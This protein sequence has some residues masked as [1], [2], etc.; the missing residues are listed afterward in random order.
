MM[1]MSKLE[2]LVA[3]ME[4][5]GRMSKILDD[6]GKIAPSAAALRW[7]A[8]R[9]AEVSGAAKWRLAQARTL[10]LLANKYRIGLN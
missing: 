6:E 10:I 7:V 1:N 4:K 5:S 2:K 9:H 8:Q 3:Q